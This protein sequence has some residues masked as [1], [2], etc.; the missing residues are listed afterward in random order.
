MCRE[1]IAGRCQ[2]HMISTLHHYS[3]A[4]MEAFQ[5]LYFLAVRSTN[6]HFLLLVAFSTF[7]QIDK[8]QALFFG[9]CFYRDG[10]C[11]WQF[12][13]H[14]EHFHKRAGHH[15]ALIIEAESYRHVIRAVARCLSIRKQLAVQGAEFIHLIVVW[16]LEVGR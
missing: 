15:F 10:K 13:R 12:L 11:V 5:N 7:L 4:C 6:L 1:C 14:E 9:Q 16:C 8:V 3:I 2:L